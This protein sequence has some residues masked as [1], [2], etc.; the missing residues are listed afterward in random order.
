LLGFFDF[1]LNLPFEIPLGVIAIMSGDNNYDFPAF[2]LK[3]PV[4]PLSTVYEDES[5]FPKISEKVADFPWHT[6]NHTLLG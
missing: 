3:L 5:R 6:R 4:T 2:S 1:F